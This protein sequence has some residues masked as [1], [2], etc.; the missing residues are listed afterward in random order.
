MADSFIQVTSGAGP[1]LSTGPTYTD[2]AGNVVQTQ[3]VF[4]GEPY[5]ATF[6]CLASGFSGTASGAHLLQVMAGGS[7]NVR[8]KEI[9][10][11]QVAAST[12][13]AGGLDIQFLRLTTAGT[14]GTTVT[15]RSFDTTD[16]IGATSMFLP[17]VKGTEGAILWEEGLWCATATATSPT[18]IQWDSEENG[19][20]II[21]PAGT[22]NGLAV[23]LVSPG[24]ATGVTITVVVR[25]T[26]TIY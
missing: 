8:I 13:S 11:K 2:N 16:S 4:L 1:K 6:T 14:G 9:V 22:A 25:G 3:K 5:E 23:K 20:P 7:L 10:V 15:P 21:I 12:S 17:T 24:F 26:E 19:K 18:S